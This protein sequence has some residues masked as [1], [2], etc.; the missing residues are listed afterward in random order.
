MDHEAPP[1]VD[2][3]HLASIGALGHAFLEEVAGRLVVAVAG[4]GV[5]LAGPSEAFVAAMEETLLAHVLVRRLIARRGEAV[6]LPRAECA[7]LAGMEAEKHR[8]AMAG[9]V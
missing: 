1:A 2:T 3:I 7:A 9:A 8:Q 5:V 4:Q 6:T